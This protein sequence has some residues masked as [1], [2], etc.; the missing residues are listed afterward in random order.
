[1]SEKPEEIVE[2]FLESDD[3]IRG[4]N[5]VCMSFISPEDVLA[6]KEIFKVQHFLKDLISKNNINLSEDY[7]EKLE[8]KYKD[9]VYNIDD[10]LEREFYKQNDFRTTVRGVK[11]RGVY[12]TDKEAQIRA[13]QLQRRDKNFN[14]YVG[15]VGFWLPWNPAPHKIEHQEYFENELNELVHKYKENQTDKEDHFRENIEYVKEQADKKVKEQKAQQKVLAEA[16]EQKKIEARASEIDELGLK[17][18]TAKLKNQ[19]MTTISEEQPVND[20]STEE[21]DVN[22]EVNTEEVI[23]EEVKP[24]FVS[25]AELNDDGAEKMRDNLQEIDPW[26]ARK[27]AG[28]ESKGE[29]IE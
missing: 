23:T 2:D 28:G 6:N 22:T 14:V 15:Q 25:N 26:M 13:K 7:I 24:D 27:M 29:S 11:I 12:D 8:E 16:E 21:N 1:M 17:R 20:V 10:Q 9:Y 19:E 18:K 3:P 5:F 4:Q